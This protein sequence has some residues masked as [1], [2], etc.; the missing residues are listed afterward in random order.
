MKGFGN[1]GEGALGSGI[2]RSVD[3]GEEFRIED[4]GDE[5]P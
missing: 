5:E 3:E 1:Q 2:R 4:G